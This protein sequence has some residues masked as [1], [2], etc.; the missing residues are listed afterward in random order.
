MRSTV[1]RTRSCIVDY[2]SIELRNPTSSHEVLQGLVRRAGQDAMHKGRRR[3][4]SRAKIGS[5]IPPSPCAFDASHRL[6]A[7]STV[8]LHRAI[9]TV[10]GTIQA[11]L[12]T[13][14]CTVR[15][16]DGTPAYFSRRAEEQVS[17]TRCA[18]HFGPR[19]RTI[20]GSIS[21][22]DGTACPL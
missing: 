1:H 18:C 12:L 11:I 3:E 20:L 22:N 19:R 8:V 9:V 14:A 10:R 21:R 6:S 2:S 7:R 4:I 13:C 16:S 5:I 15:Q 17:R